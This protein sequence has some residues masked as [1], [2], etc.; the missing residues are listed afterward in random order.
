M[1]QT[2]S[3][4]IA[5]QTPS[6]SPVSSQ[7]SAPVTPTP[8][9]TQSSIPSFET[10]DIEAHKFVAALSYLGILVFVPLLLKRDSSFARAHSA[11]GVLM[12]AAWMV[13]IFLVWIPLI[14]W[15]IGI[16]LALA[17]LV[18]FVS[19][20]QGSFWEIPVLGAHRKKLHLD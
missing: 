7:S 4:P 10:K 15:L 16:G 14:G 17:Q 9:M 12:L 18:A 20:L 2:P 3:E 8:V 1:E 6:V 19:C 13:A 11:Q 5:P